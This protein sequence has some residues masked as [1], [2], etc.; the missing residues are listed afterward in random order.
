MELEPF[1]PSP[2]PPVPLRNPGRHMQSRPLPPI[3]ETPSTKD[4]LP[5]PLFSRRTRHP[6][7]IPA[8]VLEIPDSPPSYPTYP[9]SPGSSKSSGS[10]ISSPTSSVPSSP[11][12]KTRSLTQSPTPSCLALIS[13]DPEPQHTLKR[14]LSPK[15]ETLRSL[16]AK[17]SEACLQR[18][19]EQQTLA[20]LS[21]ALCGKGKARRRLQE[22]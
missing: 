13:W 7:A 18:I 2:T 17:E 14:K 6:N 15:Y 22:D 1:T 20:Y 8:T 16:R 12:S 11:T 9:L 19:Y 5:P 3:P 10:A 4:L 21:G